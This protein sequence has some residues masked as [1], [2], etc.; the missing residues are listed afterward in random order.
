MHPS[1]PMGTILQTVYQT[2]AE[3][4]FLLVEANCYRKKYRII[5]AP[6]WNPRWH[7]GSRHGSVP[8][9]P[10]AEKFTG[11]DSGAVRL[12]APWL[13]VNLSVTRGQW[14]SPRSA[15]PCARILQVHS[16]SCGR[17]RIEPVAPT[18]LRSW[19]PVCRHS[20]LEDLWK[21]HELAVGQMQ[22]L[23]DSK[24]D[25][26]CIPHKIHVERKGSYRILL[27]KSHSVKFIWTIVKQSNCRKTALRQLEVWMASG[28]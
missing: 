2:V 23:E 11:S 26:L 4:K 24:T 20:R 16:I 19:L 6:F 21:Y 10:W 9:T 5:K 28:C 7:T 27:E 8:A 18:S 14:D 17:G 15:L 3:V 22:N 1:F 12:T 25:N 13:P